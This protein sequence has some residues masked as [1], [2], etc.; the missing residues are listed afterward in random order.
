MKES[1]WKERVSVFSP[2]KFS[3]VMTSYKKHIPQTL[4]VLFDARMREYELLTME[5]LKAN[6]EK[7]PDK[8]FFKTMVLEGDL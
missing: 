7:F 6:K 4:S 5:Y 8:R 3:D 2:E 1:E